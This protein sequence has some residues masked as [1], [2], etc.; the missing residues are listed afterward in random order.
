[1][2]LKDIW[3][4]KVDNVDEVLAE[5]INNIVHQVIQNEEDI[6]NKVNKV[7]G[8]GLSTNDFTNVEKEKLAGLNN[9][10]DAEIKEEIKNLED[11]ILKLTT[12]TT[13]THSL[14]DS[15]KFNIVGLNM[16]GETTQ[17]GT[18]A[19]DNPV[20]IVSIENPTISFY[21]KNLDT[22][23]HFFSTFP[24]VETIVEDGRNCIR[25]KDNQAKNSPFI[26]QKETQYTFSFYA[27]RKL[28]DG[29]TDG[30]KNFELFDIYYTDGTSTRHFITSTQAE[31]NK[32]V[33][34]V[35]TSNVNKSIDY[36]RSG[37]Y[38]NIYWG[39]IDIDT[40]QIEIGETATEYEPYKDVQSV[41]IP[42]TFATGDYLELKNNLIKININGN[43]T[44]I[45]D[46]E[47]GQ[48]L[49]NLY[50]NYPNTT[51][52]CDADCNIT[53]K[54]DTTN[55]YNNLKNTLTQAIISLGGTI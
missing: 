9:Y 27:K 2:A 42:Y 38:Q 39:Y 44:D 51:I 24:Y 52:T 32:W 20:D 13:K 16:Y 36:I 49:L 19:P 18:P 43:E 4:D 3:K 6:D 34:I 12:D 40:F 54:A 48:A 53:Y 47:A 21:G 26:F 15:A 10:D 55:A 35:I 29:T 37:I 33:K 17:D 5:D 8:K 1:M 7:D 50:T 28:Q 46:T 31:N 25:Y 41:E 45:T 23:E 14:N 22:A 30:N 11:N